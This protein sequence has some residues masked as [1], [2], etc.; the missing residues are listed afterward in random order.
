MSKL[1]EYLGSAVGY[2]SDGL[3]ASTTQFT[4]GFAPFAVAE[5]ENIADVSEITTI[6]QSDA[7]VDIKIVDDIAMVSF[8]F[9]NETQTLAEVAQEFET[10]TAQK[11]H[12]TE[13]L[14]RL[15]AEL[16][17]AERNEDQDAIDDL[18]AQIRSMSV[19]FMMPTIMPVCFG[20]TVHVGFTDDPKFV[21]FTSDKLNQEPCTVT[22]IFDAKA[23]FCQDEV[24][25]YTEDTDEELLMRQEELWYLEE[26]KKLEEAEYQAQFGYQNDLYG[27]DDDNQIDKRLKGVRIK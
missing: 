17:V 8:D 23:V 15:M 27:D 14:N 26:A 9:S 6:C 1:T 22:M 12:V 2:D 24:A 10:Y 16:G 21:L 20:G 3:P 25:I 18:Y 13:A 11:E 5:T 19:P 7:I 4:F